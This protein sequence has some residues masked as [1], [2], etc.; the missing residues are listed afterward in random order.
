MKVAVI[1]STYNGHTYLKEQLDSILNQQG[2]GVE[3]FIR[4][5]GSTDGT[6]EILENYSNLYE[7]C[8]VNYGEN[9]SF[10]HSFMTELKRAEGYDYYA[11][12][13]QDDFWKKKK[14]CVAC[15]M[16]YDNEKMNMSP[17]VYYSNLYISDEGLNIFKKTKHEKRQQSIES[18]VMRR[19]IAGCTMVFNKAMWMCINR[20]KITSEMLKRGHDSFILSLC[21]AVNGK[22]VCD[23]NAYICYRQHSNNTSGS[24]HTITQRMRKEW[25]AIAKKKGAEPAIA[26]SILENWSDMINVENK[27]KLEIIADSKKIGCRVKIL[28]SPKFTTGDWKLT[29]LGKLRAI[30]GLL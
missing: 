14:L 3:L 24:T 5:D 1:M 25:N 20:T 15:N 11:F 30:V 28:F 17:V 4:D 23:P 8:H 13:D 29:L 26:R 18:L 22:V 19:S 21:Y 27:Q 16:I 2:I 9:L 7:N 10:R 12:S 6:K